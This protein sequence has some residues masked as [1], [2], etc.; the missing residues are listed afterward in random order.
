MAKSRED[1]LAEIR[2]LKDE[3]DS[4]AEQLDEAQETLDEISGLVSPVC[5]DDDEDDDD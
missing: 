3:R 2:T 4:L 5:D 1:Y